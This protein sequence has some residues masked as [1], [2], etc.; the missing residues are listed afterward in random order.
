MFRRS[1]WFEAANRGTSYMAMSLQSEHPEQYELRSH[2]DWIIIEL[3]QEIGWETD[4]VWIEKLVERIGSENHG[5]A[6]EL[7]KNTYLHSKIVALLVAC[8]KVARK[9]GVRFVLLSPGTQVV[10]TLRTMRLLDTV[11][12]VCDSEASLS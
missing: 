7:E 4:Y 12:S 9:Q 11:V 10:H 2:G 6:L 1:Y 5:I 3:K 8:S